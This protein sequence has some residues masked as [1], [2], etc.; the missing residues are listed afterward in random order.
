[1]PLETKVNDAY[2]GITNKIIESL[3]KGTVPW[4]KT[5]IREFPKNLVSKRNYR[6]I[7]SFMLISREF[8]NPYWATYKQ[9]KDFG[10]YVRR[11]EK[12]TSIVLLFGFERF[13]G[14]NSRPQSAA[15]GVLFGGSTRKGVKE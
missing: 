13:S 8:S 7:N 5:W 3:E 9:V 2:E 4:K 14:T 10:G 6:G 15:R 12:G 1:M 11:D